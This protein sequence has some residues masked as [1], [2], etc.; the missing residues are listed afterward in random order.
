MNKQHKAILAGSV[1]MLQQ[2]CQA[3]DCLPLF[4]IAVDC[5]DHTTLHYFCKDLPTAQRIDIL[6]RTLAFYREKEAQQS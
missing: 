4:T 1:D 2:I 5:Q 3:H 6:E